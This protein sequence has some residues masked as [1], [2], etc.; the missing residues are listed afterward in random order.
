ML[1]PEVAWDNCGATLM[2]KRVLNLGD[3][4][5][6]KLKCL[7]LLVVIMGYYGLSL[8]AE[9]VCMSLMKRHPSKVVKLSDCSLLCLTT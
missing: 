7:K 2:D 6:V 1:E 4:K 5:M 3:E 9:K 8:L